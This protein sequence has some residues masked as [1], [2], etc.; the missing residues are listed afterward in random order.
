MGMHIENLP[1]LRVKLEHLDALGDDD[2]LHTRRGVVV[3]R[4]GLLSFGRPVFGSI[5]VNVP[6]ASLLTP[7]ITTVTW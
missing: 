5:T 7:C 1:G 2:G 6:E 4:K 3:G